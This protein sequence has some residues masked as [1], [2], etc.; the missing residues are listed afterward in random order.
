MDIQTSS[1][2]DSARR[3]WGLFTSRNFDSIVSYPFFH[4]VES[5][6]KAYRSCSLT[7]DNRQLSFP[8]EVDVGNY[9]NIEEYSNNGKVQ[10][11]FGW[12]IKQGIDFWKDKWNKEHMVSEVEGNSSDNDAYKCLTLMKSMRCFHNDIVFDPE[13]V[14]KCYPVLIA[15]RN[16]G[17]LC[18]VAK[19]YF[20]LGKHLLSKIHSDKTLEKM[21]NGDCKAVKDLYKSL[22]QIIGT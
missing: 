3:T 22:V 2:Y 13:Y 11:L 20:T 4:S 14:T 16:C 9:K 6:C 17:W 7:N 19:P 21:Q 10:W 15:A 5:L 1:A 12:A 18:L 8:E